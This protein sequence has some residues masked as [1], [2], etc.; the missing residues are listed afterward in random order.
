MSTDL[1][2]P[3]VRWDG[4]HLVLNLSMLEQRLWQV[5]GDNEQVHSLLLCG[6]GDSVRVL[7][8][9]QWKGMRVKVGLEL[10]E[11]RLRYRFLGFRIRRLRAFGR[12]PVPLVAIERLIKLFGPEIVKVVDGQGIVVVDLRRWIPG[13]LALSILTVQATD[14]LLHVWLGPGELSDIPVS[15]SPPALPAGRGLAPSPIQ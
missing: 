11:I 7:A 8:T 14:R 9:L 6:G 5:V 1:L 13:E 4:L 3:L 2:D 15:D 10:A 12:V